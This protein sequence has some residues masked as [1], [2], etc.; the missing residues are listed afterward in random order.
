M[1]RIIPNLE[2]IPV[3]LLLSKELKENIT[4]A[5]CLEVVLYPV[6]CKT[7]AHP[8]CKPCIDRWTLKSRLCPNKC[9]YMENKLDP[10]ARRMLDSVSLLCLNH[11]QGCTQQI[12]YEDFIRHVTVHC[13]YSLFECLA[14]GE[15][16]TKS[17]ISTHITIC[18]EVNNPC[19][20]CGS[21]FKRRFIKDHISV[22][23]ERYIMCG[24]GKKVENEQFEGH[25]DV[26]EYV[27]V[28]CKYCGEIYLK[29]KEAEHIMKT[30]RDNLRNMI[31]DKNMRIKI[32]T[33]AKIEIESLRDNKIEENRSSAMSLPDPEKCFYLMT[34][35]MD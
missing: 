1:E 7:C 21:N 3:E 22:C 13:D 5:I 2:N 28:T 14:C 12:S 9:K 26:C 15:D 16:G 8:F 18:E 10:L 24:C 31:Y 11:K 33:S 20:Y 25:L 27:R 29:V 35:E 34:F 4:C 17:E 19:P 23:P 6:S 30:C 32:D